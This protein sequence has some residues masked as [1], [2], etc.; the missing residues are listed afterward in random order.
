MYPN[1][2]FE[3]NLSKTCLITALS[4]LPSLFLSLSLRSRV[5]SLLPSPLQLLFVH[6]PQPHLLSP[7]LPT[8]PPTA[9]NDLQEV[10]LAWQ[11]AGSR[12]LLQAYTGV[13][14][15]AETGGVHL[16]A[17]LLSVGPHLLYVSACCPFTLAMWHHRFCS[18]HAGKSVSRTVKQ[19]DFYLSFYLQQKQF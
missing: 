15:A 6:P 13:G 17:L 12:S 2:A 11:R 14:A 16:F 7:P 1:D 4:I 3:L 19:N 8:Q 18:V 5:F 9:A 10:R